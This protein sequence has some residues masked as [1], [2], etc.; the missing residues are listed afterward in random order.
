[1]GAN[2]FYFMLGIVVY[3]VMTGQIRW[4]PEWFFAAWLVYF[5]LYFGL[6]WIVGTKIKSQGIQLLMM[7]G[8]L[9]AGGIF[10]LW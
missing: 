8:Y 5:F 6:A 1:M 9:V 7:Y 3:G 2:A 10:L 4:H